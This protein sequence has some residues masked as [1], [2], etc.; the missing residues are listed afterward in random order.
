[1][2]NL[3]YLPTDQIHPNP[4]NP[5]KSFDPEAMAELVISIREIGILQPVVVV[6]ADNGQYRLVAGERRWRAAT[7]AGLAEIPAMVRELTPEQELEVMIIENLQRRNV[8]PIEEA[9]GMK[10]LLD[11]GGYTQE[12]LADKLGC[13]QGHI[14]NRLRLLELPEPVQE[15]ISRG[16]ITASHGKVLAG[17]KALPESVLKR[18]AKSIADNAVP[19][20]RAATEVYKAIA[21]HGRDLRR[22]MAEFDPAGCEGCPH[23]AMGSR[24]SYSDKPDE[25]YCLNHQCYDKKQA[26]ARQAREAEIARKAEGQLKKGQQAVDL[27]RLGY[28]NYEQINS[29]KAEIDTADCKECESRALGKV[30]YDTE[31]REVCIKPSCYRKKKMALARDEGKAARNALQEE[32]NQAVILAGLK[33]ASLKRW[34][35]GGDGGQVNTMFVMDRP[36]LIYLTAMVLGNVDPWGDR[37][38]TLYKYLKDKHGW[39]SDLF[40]RGAWGLTHHEWSDFLRMLETLSDQQ[41][42]DLI[43]EWPAIAQGLGGAA[44]WVLQQGPG[45]AQEPELAEPYSCPDE[46]GAEVAAQEPEPDPVRALIGRIIRTHYGTG[47]VVTGVS[48]PKDDGFYTVNY[49]DP[50]DK[51]KRLSAINSITVSEGIVLCEGVAL[52]VLDTEK[53]EQRKPEKLP[54]RKYLNESG[55]EIFVSTGLGSEYGTFWRSEMGGLHRVKSPAMPMVP[56]REEAQAN[57]DAWAAKR[58]LQLVEG[59][60]PVI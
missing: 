26:E 2:S 56:T 30:S 7:E 38:V 51:G 42:L 47:G 59:V 41:L 49:R 25:E 4:R 29:Y 16:I 11:E 46:D 39:E 40:K 32:M 21:E 33:A 13:S 9:H 43:F 22:G 5:R 34:Q 24:Y 14:A 1:M 58:G 54:S 37:K 28:G 20:S 44:G 50:S 52:I 45:Q 31:L 23:I 27:T 18:A 3:M 55:R 19:V 35:P 60:L 15:N 12:A 8:N 17:H 48:G 57:L 10:A 53:S 6:Q 36:T